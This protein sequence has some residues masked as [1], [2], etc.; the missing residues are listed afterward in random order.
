MNE[1]TFEQSMAEIE[2]VLR[3][4]EDGSTTLDASLAGY[5]RGIGLI[6]T[7]Y[8]KLREAEN[9][10]QLLSGIDAEG[11]P[12]LTPF[13]HTTSTEVGSAK[14][15]APAPRAKPREGGLY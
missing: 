11:K 14:A 10:I 4:L 12:V 5:E 2:R 7:C 9:R 13:D 6:K 3:D 8:G 15:K 1:L